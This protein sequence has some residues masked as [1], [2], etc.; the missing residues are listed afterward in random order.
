MRQ[1]GS[2]A[3]AGLIVVV[4][5]LS[6]GIARADAVIATGTFTGASNHIT[7][8]GVSIVKTAAGAAV[9]ILDKDFSLDG[10]PDPRVGL[11]RDGNYDKESDLGKLEY[12]DG[13]QAYVVPASVDV[14][15]HN[16]VYI[17]CR[18]F[19]VPLGI[20]ALN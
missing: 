18:K 1:F 3:I 14:S 17:W 6:G 12:N 15:K 16:E 13:L 20:A 10:A 5:A 8:G 9:V 11:G 2:S 19:S 7:T 4:F